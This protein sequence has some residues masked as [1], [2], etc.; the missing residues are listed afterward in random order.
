MA[1]DQEARRRSQRVVAQIPIRVAAGAAEGIGQ[2]AVVNRHG[3]LILCA[4]SAGGEDETGL[5]KYGIE[6]LEERPGFWG[7]EVE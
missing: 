6:L 5:R 2:T 3:A 7:F 4:V 1:D